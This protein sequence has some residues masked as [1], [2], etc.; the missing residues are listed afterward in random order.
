[1]STIL[2]FVQSEGLDAPDIGKV[3]LVT[4]PVHDRKWVYVYEGVYVN[5]ESESITIVR[6]TYNN[7]VFR[8]LV[9]IFALAL[10]KTYGALRIDVATRLA[11]KYFFKTLVSLK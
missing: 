5:L 9:G 6:G 8:L 4:K 11:R 7:N 1:M 3:F 2:R 10:Y